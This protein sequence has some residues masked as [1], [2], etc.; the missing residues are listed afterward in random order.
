[1]PARGGARE[2]RGRSLVS[3]DMQSAAMRGGGAARVYV[4]VCVC[5]MLSGRGAQRGQAAYRSTPRDKRDAKVALS[6]RETSCIP[7]G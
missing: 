2:D 1:M 6:Q 3:Q 7:R 4:C 5:V